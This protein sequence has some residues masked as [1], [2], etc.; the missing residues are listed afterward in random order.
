[1][2]MRIGHYMLHTVNGKV[3]SRTLCTSHHHANNIWQDL[4][5]KHDPFT[6]HGVPIS[7]VGEDGQFRYG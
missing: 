1:M 3:V 2:S 7:S 5:L 6:R 4:L